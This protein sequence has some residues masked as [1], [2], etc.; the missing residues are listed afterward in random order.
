M[1]DC[2]C[3]PRC[4]FFN[5]KM[6]QKPAMAQMYKKQFCR[7]DASTCARH[8]IFTQMGKEAVPVDLYPNQAD[9]A[10]KILL[11]KV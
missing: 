6:A 3:L 5:D 8:M 4:P 7:G 11:A 10:R 1:A 9:R 2:E